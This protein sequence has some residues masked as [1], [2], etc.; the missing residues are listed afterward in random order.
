PARRQMQIRDENLAFAQKRELRLERLFHFHDHVGSREKLFRLIDNLCASFGVFF[1]R[2]T[3]AGPGIRLHEHRMTTPD[4][5]IRSRRQQ[6]DTLLLFLNFFW[7]TDDHTM[8][9]K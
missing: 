5:L 9:E 8:S 1:V 3:A 4:E 2:I 7:D 6:G